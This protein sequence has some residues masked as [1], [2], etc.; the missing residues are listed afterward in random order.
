[1]NKI[2]FVAA[3]F[4][5]SSQA[6]ANLVVNGSFEDNGPEREQ[7]ASFQKFPGW[8]TVEGAGIEVRNNVVGTAQDGA[9][10]VELDSHYK[11]G[12]RYTNSAMEQTINTVVGAS[13]IYS[14]FITLHASINPAQPT[15]FLFLEQ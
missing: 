7:M 9:R 10:F 3:F 6:N 4:A 14:R 13:D 11:A 1:M 8:T 15:V 5:L 12:Q 2:L